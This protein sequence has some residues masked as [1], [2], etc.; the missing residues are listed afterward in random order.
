MRIEGVTGANAGNVNGIFEPTDEMCDG[1]PVYR[2]K[3]NADIWLE[4][5]TSVMD[6]FVRPT[7][8][9]GTS[10]GWAY[11]KL[12]S[13]CLPQDIST[14]RWHVW[15]G[16]RFELQAAA[17]IACLSPVPAHIASVID[18]IRQAELLEVSVYSVP[19]LMR[20]LLSEV[21]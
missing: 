14:G 21:C 20:L 6:W 17:S 18:V 4:F 16:E 5:N 13:L 19:L 15:T 10:K 1:L 8:S 9:R 12:E 3:G 7:S 11:V 2:K